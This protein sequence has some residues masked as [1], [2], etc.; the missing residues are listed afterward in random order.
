MISNVMAL[1]SALPPLSGRALNCS[2]RCSP[3][4]SRF[5]FSNVRVVSDRGIVK[6]R[7]RLA[8]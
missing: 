5:R 4:G 8:E 7:R 3:Y 6:L 2:S 1:L